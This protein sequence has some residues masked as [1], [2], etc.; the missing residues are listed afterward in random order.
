MGKGA[1]I[2]WF[3]RQWIIR[4]ASGA[5]LLISSPNP[6]NRQGYVRRLPAQ[7]R[8]TSPS[9]IPH[10]LLLLMLDSEMSTVI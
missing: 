2:G 3:V 6:P 4:S 9:S 1:L 7:S 8:A 10:Q 5:P